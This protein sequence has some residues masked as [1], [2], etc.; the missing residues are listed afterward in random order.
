[1]VSHHGCLMFFD[2]VFL[3]G[4]CF[5]ERS[6]HICYCRADWVGL[7]MIS[8]QVLISEIQLLCT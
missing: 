4:C 7:V 2:E 6:C 1:M 8:L 5:F 3:L